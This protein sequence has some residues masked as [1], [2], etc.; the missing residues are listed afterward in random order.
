M[1]KPQSLGALSSIQRLVTQL[2]EDLPAEDIN[3]K[4]HPDLPGIGWLLGRSIY[5]EL[6]W[7]REK[8]L[9][10][11]DLSK[12]VRQFFA[13]PLPRSAQ[14]EQ[15]LPPKEHLLNWALE[16]QDEHLSR[17]A[18]PAL[19]PDH[20]WLKNGWL[21]DYLV[22]VHGRIYE[23]MLSVRHARA[24]AQEKEHHVQ[25][26]L[27]ASPPVADSTEVSQ[28]HYR[29]GARD[30][31]MFDNEQPMQ[32][33]EMRNFR[34]SNKPA[35]NAAWLAFLEDGGYTQNEYWSKQGRNWKQRHSIT[36]PWHWRQDQDGNW[37]ALGLNGPMDLLPDL[38]VS[39]VS[40]HEARAYANW[41][42]ARIEGFSGAVLPHEYHWEA[43]ARIGALQNGGNVWEWCSNFLHPYQDYEAPVD[44]EMRTRE[45]AGEYPAL[46][47]GC[48]H[49]QA[50]L[51]RISIR[52]AGPADAGYLF[53]GVRLVFPPA[54]EEEALYIEQWQKF[55]G[56]G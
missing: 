56:D 51:R 49:T 29:I 35:D 38:P 48:I 30:G 52:S 41:A 19:L 31:V 26:P 21:V 37:Y 16:V 33:V 53:S 8:I 6:W 3:R 22:Q 32:M 23:Q 4:Y 9:G 54:L 25:Q 24:V 7:L 28:G 1:I 44:P 39:G 10:D 13:R 34:I 5:L 45:F 2:V 11:D 43:A 12:R 27:R 36:R 42:A 40:W 15:Q 50:A 47:G 14:Q 18:N 55:L 46:R 20:P 17:L